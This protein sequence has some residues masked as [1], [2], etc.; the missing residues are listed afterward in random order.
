MGIR[1]ENLDD[2]TRKYMRAESDLGGHY[3]S[4]RLN[5]QGTGAWINLLNEAIT[6]HSDDWLA[7]ELVKQ[8]LFKNRE[9]YTRQGKVH[10]R[11]INI[12]HAALQLAEGEFNRYYLRALC[13]IAQKKG[14][15]YLVVYRGKAV[16]N[17]RPESEAM[18]GKHISVEE[19]LE[20]LRS[21]DFVTIGDVLKVPGGPNSGLTARLP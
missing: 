4:P 21:N 17:P 5:D 3:R 9:N 13:R 1:Y 8:G 2:A 18:I 11:D 6:S 15:N 14:G 7:A 20:A 19:L 16:D 12:P 10:T